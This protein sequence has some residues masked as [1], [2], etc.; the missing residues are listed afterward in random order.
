MTSQACSIPD[1]SNSTEG[2]AL[3]KVI[4][5]TMER[6]GQEVDETMAK[7]NLGIDIRTACYAN[8]VQGIFKEIHDSKKYCACKFN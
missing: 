3:E 7:H 4:K 8:A 6:F 5:R 1:E 2:Q